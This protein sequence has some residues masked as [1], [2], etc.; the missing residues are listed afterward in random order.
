MQGVLKM[1]VPPNHPF[2]IILI[3]HYKPSILGYNIFWKPPYLTDK[4]LAWAPRPGPGPGPGTAPH[5]QSRPV[6]SSVSG[7][8]SWGDHQHGEA[9]RSQSIRIVN[10]STIR[11]LK[12]V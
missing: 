8:Y 10:I 9:G 11:R 12:I 2:L 5:L 7:L 3:A 4:H 6:A 1:V